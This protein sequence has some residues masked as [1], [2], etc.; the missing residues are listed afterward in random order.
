MAD[1]IKKIETNLYGNALKIVCIP[2]EREYLD[3]EVYLN[4]EL[5]CCISWPDATTFVAD[6]KAL[7]EKYRI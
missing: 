4:N 7:L 6:F 1:Q 5:L 2:C 3:S